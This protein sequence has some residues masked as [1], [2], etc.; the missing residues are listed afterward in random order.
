MIVICSVAIAGMW[1]EH[2]LLIAPAFYPKA[3]SLPLS[4]VDFG[5]ALGFLGLLVWALASYL[6]QF[7]GLLNPAEEGR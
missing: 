7:P 2:F 6:K 1:L 3:V 5:V 4:W